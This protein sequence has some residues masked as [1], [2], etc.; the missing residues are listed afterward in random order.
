MSGRARPWVWEHHKQ[1]YI[2]HGG[3]PNITDEDFLDVFNKDGEV[4]EED[5][6][7]MILM[8][9]HN[10][11]FESAGDNDHPINRKVVLR[12]HFQAGT[13]TRSHFRS[14]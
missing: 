9:E 10:T 13:Y 4:S 2:A 6:K 11:V 14:T 1:M 3:D 12:V 5:Q 7:K 8:W